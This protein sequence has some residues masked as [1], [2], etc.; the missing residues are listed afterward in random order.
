MSAAEN[1]IVLRAASEGEGLLITSGNMELM[2]LKTRRPLLVNTG[3]L[4]Q[5]SYVPASG[6]EM[7]RALTAIYGVDLFDPPEAIRIARP[8]ALLETTGKD[9]WESRNQQQWIDLGETFGTT[10]ILT[11][12]GWTLGLPLEAENDK[13]RLYRIPRQAD[14]EGLETT[15]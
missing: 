10:Q 3:A 14:P 15:P 4:D 7:N 9:L 2:Q 11:F 6:P 8:G 1:D 12:S 13:Y 5:L